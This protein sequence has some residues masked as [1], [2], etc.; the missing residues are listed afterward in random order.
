MLR[1]CLPLVCDS[2]ER[3]KVL[4]AVAVMKQVVELQPLQSNWHV[5]LGSVQLAAR[6]SG[7][8][9]ESFGLALELHVTTLSLSLRAS[10]VP[11]SSSPPLLLCAFPTPCHLQERGR[12]HRHREQADTASS[13]QR[14]E[15]EAAG[16]RFMTS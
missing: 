7:D 16:S 3:G 2:H 6:Q 12:Q 4:E 9:I 8:A 11:F 13:R 5:N 10:S 15:A 14:R 1:Q